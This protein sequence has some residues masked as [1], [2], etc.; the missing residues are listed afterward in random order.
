MAE[1]IARHHASD[2]IEPCSAGLMPLG[3]VPELTR[4][5]LAANGHSC[6]ELR[7]K[8]VTR[9]LWDAADLVINMSGIPRRRAFSDPSKVED[10]DVQDPYG[11]DPALYQTI[12]EDIERRVGELAER[13]RKSAKNPGENLAEGEEKK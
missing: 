6:A 11:N 8:P 9:E 3:V 13:L 4:Q 12:H 2:V 10:W 7:S 5:T 1:S